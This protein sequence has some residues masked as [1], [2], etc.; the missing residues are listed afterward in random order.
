MFVFYDEGK[1][2]LKKEEK[3]L[4]K[5]HSIFLNVS[6]RNVKTSKNHL[7]ATNLFTQERWSGFY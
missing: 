7:N 6:L 2:Q 4:I 3:R 1:E 5:S